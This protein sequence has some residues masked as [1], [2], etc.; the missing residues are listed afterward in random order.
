[1][2]KRFQTLISIEDLHRESFIEYLKLIFDIISKQSLNFTAKSGRLMKAD[3]VRVRARWPDN[4][5][6]LKVIC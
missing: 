3:I 4:S 6:I 1:M 2:K 5:R